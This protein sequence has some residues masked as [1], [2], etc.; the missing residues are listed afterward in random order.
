MGVPE[1]YHELQLAGTVLPYDAAGVEWGNAHKTMKELASFD[2]DSR[3]VLDYLKTNPHCT[4]RLGVMGSCFGGHLAF[5]AAL[6]PN[7]LAGA[8]FYETRIHTRSFLRGEGL[9]CDPAARLGYAIALE[10]FGRRLGG[11]RAIGSSL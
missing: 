1:I 11:D 5:R 8:C 10:L 2:A 4:G 3:A 7:V 6:N 9:R